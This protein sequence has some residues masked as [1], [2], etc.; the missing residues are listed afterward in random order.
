MSGRNWVGVTR[1]MFSAPWAINASIAD[2]RPAES[3]CRPWRRWLMAWF[4]QY[5]QPR[6]Q[7]EK[8]MAPLP[9]GPARAGSSQKWRMI[10]ATRSLPGR[11]Q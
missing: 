4:W 6:V 11:R 8:K 1:S 3:I 9:P 2:R 7:P 10:L 5:R